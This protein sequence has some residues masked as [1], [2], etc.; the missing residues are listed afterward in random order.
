MG[1][2]SLKIQTSA[3]FLKAKHAFSLHRKSSLSSNS[4]STLS[5]PSTSPP[6]SSTPSELSSSQLF[7]ST[8]LTTPPASSSSS[9]STTGAGK[10]S[11]VILVSVLFCYWPRVCRINGIYIFLVTTPFIFNIIIDSRQNHNRN[12]NRNNSNNDSTNT[13][14]QNWVNIGICIDCD[15]CQVP[16][17]HAAQ[18]VSTSVLCEPV[19]VILVTFDSRYSEIPLAVEIFQG[20]YQSGSDA[21]FDLLSCSQPDLAAQSSN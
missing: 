9:S 3:L 1:H 14:Q 8:A 2:L 16:K 10:P 21:V 18:S 11:S 7:S 19:L 12:R 6:S 15:S 20:Q 17:Y 13:T 4:S 5:S